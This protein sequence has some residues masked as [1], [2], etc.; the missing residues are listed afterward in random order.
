MMNDEQNIIK[1]LR[2][3]RIKEETD[4]NTTNLDEI[5]DQ[6]DNVKLITKEQFTRNTNEN[7]QEINAESSKKMKIKDEQRSITEEGIIKNG[8]EV[9]KIV[10]NFSL[11]K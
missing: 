6:T 1:E 2:E 7:Q 4:E 8:Y 10:T 11:K 9:V 5:Q 3:D